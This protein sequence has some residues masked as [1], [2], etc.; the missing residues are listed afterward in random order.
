MP[1]LFFFPLIVWMGMLEMARDEMYVPAK[2]T[3][4][5]LERR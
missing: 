5:R 3:S 4:P 1:L 2:V